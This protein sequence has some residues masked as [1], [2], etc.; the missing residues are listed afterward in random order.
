[1]FTAVLFTIARN[2]N[3]LSVLQ[4]KDEERKCSITHNEILPSCKEKNEI[5]KFAG[6]WMEQENIILNEATQ[7]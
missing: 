2:G 7:I 1:M 6:E 4:L 3:N 5:A